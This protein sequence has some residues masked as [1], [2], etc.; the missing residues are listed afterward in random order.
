MIKIYSFAIPLALAL[1][2]VQGCGYTRV[3][4][5]DTAPK[6]KTIT[7]I[8]YNLSYKELEF[9]GEVEGYLIELGMDVYNRPPPKWNERKLGTDSD[10]EESET[11]PGLTSTRAQAQ[12]DTLKQSYY[13]Y[14]KKDIVTEYICDTSYESGTMRLLKKDTGMVLGIIDLRWSR[15]EGV[16]GVDDKAIIRL[17]IDKIGIK[18]DSK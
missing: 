13:A 17:F 1:S 11:K 15:Y 16:Q 3:V 5:R 7:V 6:D 10:K 18:H 4:V 9:C 2:I 12:L 8:P 14:D